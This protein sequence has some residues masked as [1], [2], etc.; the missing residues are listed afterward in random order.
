METPDMLV[1]TAGVSTHAAMLGGL[2]EAQP[3]VEALT[4]LVVCAV[5][6]AWL[7][8]IISDIKISRHRQRKRDSHYGPSER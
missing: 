3:Q 7:V 6:L 8:K 2:V 5:M 4:S 1:I